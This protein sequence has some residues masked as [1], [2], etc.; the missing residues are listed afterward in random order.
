MLGTLFAALTAETA[1]LLAT[2]LSLR[3]VQAL[4]GFRRCEPIV[5]RG[6]IVVFIDFGRLGT[7]LIAIL[8]LLLRRGDNAEVMLGVLQIVLGKDRIPRGLRIA[9]ELQIFFRDVGG[10]AAHLH[11]RSIG[12]EIP[13]QRIDVLA[14]AIV[15]PAPLAVLVVLV[16]SHRSRYA[17]KMSLWVEW[18]EARYTSGAH[19]GGP[20][21]RERVR[22]LCGLNHM[23]SSRRAG[24]RVRGYPRWQSSVADERVAIA[25]APT[26]AFDS[27]GNLAASLRYSKG[28]M[29]P[30]LLRFG[31]L[32]YGKP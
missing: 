4:D 31:F 19:K 11:V 24:F 28:K 15:V 2:W 23:G 12:F 26:R 13:A 1:L 7:R 30:V 32:N 5:D 22:E 27:N 16:G 29:F 10:V 14:P 3:L 25:V 18:S 21:G 9:S 20:E 8:Q 6:E 17:F